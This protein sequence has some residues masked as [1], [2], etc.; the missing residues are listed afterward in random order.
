MS[1]L[2]PLRPLD[3]SSDRT[4]GAYFAPHPLGHTSQPRSSIKSEGSDLTLPFQS[5]LSSSSSMMASNFS[6]PPLGRNSVSAISL[7]A[8][9]MQ[10]LV[11]NVSRSASP[12]SLLPNYPS[13]VS[14]HIK[15]SLSSLH[16]VSSPPTL[17][18]F[19]GTVAFAAPWM[20][21]AQCTTRMYVGGVC[22]SIEQAYFEPTA[23]LSTVSLSP[24]TAPLPESGL[25]SCR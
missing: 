11:V 12:A 7:S 2:E 25:T 3:M 18:G 19:S 1:S 24:V 9:G 13:H 8:A 21:V 20:S 6:P 5:T 14:I 4:P 23:P 22:E 17:H 15:L 16:D 10:P